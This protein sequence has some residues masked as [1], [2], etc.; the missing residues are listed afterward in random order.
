[1]EIADFAQESQP[2]AVAWDKLPAAPE[3]LVKLNK[4]IVHAV[5]DYQGMT[6]DEVRA[7]FRAHR[8]STA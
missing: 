8:T 3:T 7:F 6:A 5:R 4:K 1:M 2:M